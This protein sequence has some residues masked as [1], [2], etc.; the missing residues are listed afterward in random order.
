M[1][2][3]RYESLNVLVVDDFTNFRLTVIKMLQEF[4]CR[5]VASATNGNTAVRLCEEHSYDVVLCDYNLGQG[6]NGQQV[7]EELRHRGLLRR[8]CLFV[9]LSAESSLSI[10]LSAFDYAPDAYLTKPITGNTLKKRLDRLLV[11]RQVMY[12]VLSDLDQGDTNGAIAKARAAIESASRYATI[13]QKLLAELLLQ[14]QNP[15]AAETVYRQVLEV[16]E[17]DW[18]QVGMAR[19]KLAQGDVATAI[20]WSNDIIAENPHCMMAYDVL[21]EAYAQIHDDDSQQQIL[22]AAVEI[23][24][25]SI[26][27]QLS[28]AR[29]ADANHDF[30]VAAKAYTRTVRLG[31]NSC[32]DK[33]E[34]HLQLGRAS[35][36][37]YNDHDAKASDVS[38]EALR[39][40]DTM[41]KRFTLDKQSS[42]Q[43]QMLEC[44]LLKKRGENLQ[45]ERVFEEIAEQVATL[46]QD[47]TLDSGLDLVHT[48]QAMEQTQDAEQ[49][50]QKLLETY[51][52]DEAALQKLDCLFEEPVSATNREK[53]AELNKQGIHQY[54]CKNYN[55]AID[56]FVKARR[57]F[58]NHV[59]VHLNLVQVLVADMKAFGVGE[60]P[61]QEC[62]TA[63]EKVQNNITNNHPQFTRFRQLQ[64]MVRNLGREAERGW[65]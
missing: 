9:M 58:P 41:T 2:F 3:Q 15:A 31:L 26:M 17:L 54:E 24:P 43:A 20:A 52:D 27:R 46:E 59:G 22:L 1:G 4:G 42:L 35:I 32:H 50:I 63:L 6:K 33:P 12:P 29:T 65:R 25:R 55:S 62:L 7:L 8:T 19:A 61:M 53:V 14:Q 21:A 56:C 5:D 18:A 10:V 40:L 36:Q 60:E 48:Y 13:Y 34:H 16:R 57:L 38:R 47:L 37:L 49:L 44:Q 51:R 64:E 45:A 39:A 11:Q 23:S 28:L 30:P